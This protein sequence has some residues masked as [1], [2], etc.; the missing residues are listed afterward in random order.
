MVERWRSE[1]LG[2]VEVAVDSRNRHEAGAGGLNV[3]DGRITTTVRKVRL[4]ASNRLLASRL[5]SRPAL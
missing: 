1:S 4:A 2:V 5:S 3:Q